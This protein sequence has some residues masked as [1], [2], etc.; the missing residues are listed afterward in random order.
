MGNFDEEIKTV[1][2]STWH[3]VGSSSDDQQ[4][5]ESYN[6]KKFGLPTPAGT[7]GGACTC[8]LLKHLYERQPTTTWWDVFNGVQTNLKSMGFA[9]QTPT[10]TSSRKID[11]K[12]E[13]LHIVPPG[14]NKRRAL[15]IGINYTGQVAELR[16]C[17][18]DC[19]NLKNYL[20]NRE[21]FNESEM[22]IL[23]D[24]GKH[25]PP[26]KENI[27]NAFLKLAQYSRAGDVNFISFSGHGGQTEDLDGVRSGFGDICRSRS[28]AYFHIPGRRGRNGFNVS[29]VVRSRR[30]VGAHFLPD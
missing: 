17:Q 12:K 15:L 7:S 30:W 10:F 4:S 20:I 13:K 3:V 19:I 24:D 29:I 26:T 5:N 6:V 22:M 11:L 9:N 16:S 18:N 21:G 8:L 14:S 1:I 27:Q 28:C 2:P 23:M 25:T